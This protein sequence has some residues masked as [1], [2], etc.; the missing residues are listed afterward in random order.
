MTLT[1]ASAAAGETLDAAWKKKKKHVFLFTSSGKPVYTRHGDESKLASLVG[2]L[3]GLVSFVERLQ[4]T[5]GEDELLWVR[6]G[7]HKIVFRSLAPLYCC[8]V[9]STG[10]S[11]QQ[12]RAQLDMMHAQVLAILTE[13][14]VRVLRDNPRFDLRHLLG[15]AERFLH[16]LSRDMDRAGSPYLLGAVPALRLPSSLRQS[17]GS[18]LQGARSSEQL[19]YALL[20]GGGQLVTLVRPK[21]HLLTAPDLLLLA[22]FVAAAPAFKESEATLTPLCL[23]HFNARGFLHLYTSYVA[24]DV[25]LLLLATAAE[26]FPEMAATKDRILAAQEPLRAL[27]GALG[28]GGP[29]AYTVEEVGVPGLLHFLYKSG[30][31]SQLTA[32]TC[33]RGPYAPGPAQKRLFRIYQRVHGAVTRPGPD[34]AHK[35]YL[36]RSGRETIVAWR[37]AAFELY[38]AF[39]PLVGKP[40]A[41]M[42]CNFVLKW[43][44]QEE[45]NLFLLSA[46]IW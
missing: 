31:L 26:A 22:N 40:E 34:R 41:I 19:F 25:C 8:T 32:P 33:V 28:V 1:L 44:K 5:Q 43:I 21:K 29:A 13:T 20:L 10:E 37:T 42:G 6:A 4:H 2:V 16:R 9:A 11:E 18:L 27:Q 36:E 17:L 14:A 46:P 30:P 23:P 24:P 39:G 38:A 3:V 7:S 12:L 15:G 45:T 35:V